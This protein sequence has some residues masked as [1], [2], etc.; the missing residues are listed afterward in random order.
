[1]I[2]SRELLR[3]VVLATYTDG[4]GAKVS[5]I[6]L[7][8]VGD[9]DELVRVDNA[10][11]LL[12]TR[13]MV[14]ADPKTSIVRLAV[15]LPDAN[16]ARQVAQGILD[17]VNK[18]NLVK[19]QSQARAERAFAERRVL[20]TKADLES[21]EN[22]LQVF[23]TQNRGFL[24]S[25]ELKVRQDRL[26][27]ELSLRQRLFNT[28]A[29]TFEQARLDEVRDTPVIT[30][31]ESPELAAQP[32]RRYLALK[33]FLAGIVGSVL[34]AIAVLAGVVL[35]ALIRSDPD[36]WAQLRSRAAGAPS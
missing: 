32:D 3:D 7:L 2:R 6:A 14:S 23:M 1:L 25:S 10:V 9:E 35:R 5:L 29:E 19:R 18:F 11:R 21:A 30:V 26:D 16:V 20:E 34:A 36:G 24:G 13:M 22:Q 28:L 17:R 4:S 31:L 27:R 12:S 15:S 8:R 33:I